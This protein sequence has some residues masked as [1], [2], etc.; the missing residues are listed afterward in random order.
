MAVRFHSLDVTAVRRLTD[1]A[2]SATLG[3]PD[4]LRETFAFQPGQYV[5]LRAEIGGE[6]VRRPYSICSP[7]NGKTIDVGIKHVPGGRFSTFA[8]QVLQAGVRI[9]VMAPEGQFVCAADERDARRDGVRRDYLLIG[10]GSGIT[11]LMSIAQSVLARGGDDT[12]TL[13]FGNRTTGDIMFREDI[14]EL[15]DRYLD[16]F[17]V[18]HFLSRERQDVEF[19]NGRIDEDRLGALMSRGLVDIAN[20]EAIYICGPGEMIDVAT[21]VFAARDVPAD[22]IRHERFTPATDAA[23]RSV[24]PDAT[25]VGAEDDI[26]INVVLDG[27]SRSFT[28]AQS[29]KSIITAAASAG[30]ELP[31]S[32]AGG[33]CCTCRCRVVEGALDL[34]VNYSLEQWELDAGFTL[35]CQARPITGRIVLDFDAT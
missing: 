15:K 7:P 34:S 5:T 24:I 8:N 28:M 22:K 9:D 2:V 29:D 26:E 4:G 3:I 11:P 14:D 16:R 1:S 33:M 17:R 23:P 18:F 6:D 13:V 21:R 12:V 31:Y 25:A 35:A 19:L 10:A 20:A 27:V 32:C 30:I